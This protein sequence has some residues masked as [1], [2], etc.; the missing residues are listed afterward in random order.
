MVGL[1]LIHTCEGDP[2]G[3]LYGAGYGDKR[4][5]FL[6]QTQLILFDQRWLNAD[7]HVLLYFI[8]IK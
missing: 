3:V 5:V 4:Y 8:M 6:S 2:G 1:K 7:G